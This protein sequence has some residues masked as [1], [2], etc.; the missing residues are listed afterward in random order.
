MTYINNIFMLAEIYGQGC[1]TQN[2]SF[3]TSSRLSIYTCANVVYCINAFTGLS[4]III[5]KNLTEK[6]IEN[7]LHISY[8][9]GS[10][11]VLP[12]SVLVAA[13]REIHFDCMKS[14]HRRVGIYHKSFANF[15]TD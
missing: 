8:D 13:Q 11:F 10:S 7:D 3:M 12:Q 5:R 6:L 9:D 15:R 2:F 1:F 14:N 4:S